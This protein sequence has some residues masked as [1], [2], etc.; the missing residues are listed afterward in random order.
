MARK[1][2]MSHPGMAQMLREHWIEAVV[3][4]PAERVAEQARSTAP[5]L[6]GAYKNSIHVELVMTG[7]VVARV[8]ASD[9]K[10]PLIEA[11]TGNLARA[12][13]AARG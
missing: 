9:R 10:A 13:A 4:G 2:Q 8:V 5:V 11:R 3:R 12:L 7:R 6:T 1:F